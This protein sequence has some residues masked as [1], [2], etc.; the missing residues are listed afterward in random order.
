MEDPL[1]HAVFERHLPSPGE[2]LY[3]VPKG[4]VS[5]QVWEEEILF[6]FV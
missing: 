6:N 1:L 3:I 4:V 5:G 2:V